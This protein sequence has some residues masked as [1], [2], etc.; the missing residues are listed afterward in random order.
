[1]I[2]G[3]DG[4]SFKKWHGFMEYVYLD[5]FAPSIRPSIHFSVN[6]TLLRPRTLFC[7]RF[8][9]V[10]RNWDSAGAG[11]FIPRP[12]AVDLVRAAAYRRAGVAPV[13]KKEGDKLNLVQVSRVNKRRILN[14]QELFA[15]LQKQ[16][17]DKVDVTWV[18]EE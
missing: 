10:L 3:Q 1:M 6:D 5:L 15:A 2:A 11:D 13:T 4:P 7:D 9:V 16:F 8:L 18:H 12:L 17:A 14:E